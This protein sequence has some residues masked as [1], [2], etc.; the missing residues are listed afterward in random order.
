MEVI[1]C[2]D[3]QAVGRIAADRIAKVLGRAKAPVLGV[4]TGSTP[5][6]TYSSLAALAAR[7]RLTLLI[8]APLP[9]TNTLGFLQTM[10]APTQL[11]SAT[12]SPNSWDS[13]RPTSTPP[14]AWPMTSML[15]APHTRQPS[16]RLMASMFRSLALGQMDILVSMSHQFAVFA[17]SRQDPCGAHKG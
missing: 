2:S 11:P 3:E 7:V 16:R 13:I 6:T 1:I 8:C 9:L 4:A 10:S 15:P 12:P 14:T 17:H 5:L